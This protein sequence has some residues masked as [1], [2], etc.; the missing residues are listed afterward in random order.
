MPVNKSQIVRHGL[1]MAIIV[2]LLSNLLACNF[3]GDEE[4]VPSDSEAQL[5]RGETMLFAYGCATC[6]KISGIADSPGNIGP[7][8]V[9]WERRK[10]IAGEL[11]NEP[12]MLIRWIMKPQEVEPGTAMPDLGITKDDAIDMAAYLYN[13]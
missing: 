6:H 3:L 12:E 1:R 5:D 13:Q 10:Y 8:L 11:P 9:N 4:L 7:P 2:I